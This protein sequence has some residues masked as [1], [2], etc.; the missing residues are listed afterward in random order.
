L[1]AWRCQTRSDQLD[2]CETDPLGPQAASF[3]HE[4]H[5]SQTQ[6]GQSGE[7]I[8]VSKGLSPIRE[9]TAGQFSDNEGVN[10]ELVIGYQISHLCLKST[11]AEHLHPNGNIGENHC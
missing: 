10:A 6:D 5:I 3:D 4:S 1:R 7:L 9:S 11:L 2:I 8:E